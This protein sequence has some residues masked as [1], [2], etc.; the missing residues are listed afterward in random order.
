MNGDRVIRDEVS[1]QADT[2]DIAVLNRLFAHRDEVQFWLDLH[3]ERD[4]YVARHPE[5]TAGAK[6]AN[7]SNRRQ[8]KRHVATETVPTFVTFVAKGAKD[9]GQRG[10]SA[11]KLRRILA[12]VDFVGREYLSELVALPKRRAGLIDFVHDLDRALTQAERE[13]RVDEWLAEEPAPRRKS[14]D[15]QTWRTALSR[16]DTIIASLNERERDQFISA[17]RARLNELDGA[18]Y[19]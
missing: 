14:D 7:E 15:D 10:W 4:A 2:T 8:A 16:T 12:C 19:G 1:V 11:T 3:V 13:E 9:H 5:S 17:L 6:Q 18:R